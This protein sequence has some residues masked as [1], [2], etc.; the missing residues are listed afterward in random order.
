MKTNKQNLKEELATLVDDLDETQQISLIKSKKKIKPNEPFVLT[1]YKNLANAF[2]SNEL[3]KLD[4]RVLFTVIQYVSFGN[5]IN[6]TQQ[7]IAEDL[8]I[9][10][11][12]VSKSFKRL[13]KSGI[14][15]REKSSLFLNPNYLCK[16]DLFKSKETEAYKNV[17]NNLYKELGEFIKDPTE[18]EKKVYETMAF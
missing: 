2:S 6:L 12:Q 7:T 9:D 11:S 15:Y 16:G 5:V 17:R 13:E 10:Q 3:T 18:L 14:I 1:F 8:K 4:V